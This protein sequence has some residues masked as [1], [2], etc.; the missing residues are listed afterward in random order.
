MWTPSKFVRCHN[1]YLWCLIIIATHKQCRNGNLGAW[2]DA[3]ATPGEFV[4]PEV[5]ENDGGVG[6]FFIPLISQ[7]FEEDDQRA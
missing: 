5:D 6:Q 4:A 3:V 1:V 2:W 7:L